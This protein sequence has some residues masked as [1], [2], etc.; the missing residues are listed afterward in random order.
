MEGNTS[1]KKDNGFSIKASGEKLKTVNENSFIDYDF[2]GNQLNNF[3]KKGS[4][5]VG[6]HK[7][8][9]KNFDVKFIAHTHPAQTLKILCSKKS[10]DFSKMRLFPDQVVFNGAKSCLVPYARPGSELTNAVINSIEKFEKKENFFPKLI[11]LKNHG[12]ISC[13]KSIEECLVITEICEKAAEIF[14]SPF[15]LNFL[16]KTQIQSILDDD[17][18]IYR[19]KLII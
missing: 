14:L 3:T 4:I 12:I 18:E 15:S 7:Y 19:Q 13:G 8:I 9:L 11:L 16:S 6:F 17:N 5:E 1:E 2:E 10:Y